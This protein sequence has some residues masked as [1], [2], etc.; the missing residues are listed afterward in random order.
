MY[1]QL[2]SIL[3]VLAG[4]GYAPQVKIDQTGIAFN[5]RQVK[6]VHVDHGILE[7]KPE[8]AAELILD[9]VEKALIGEDDE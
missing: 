4:K 9:E 2:C 7:Q 6:K 1:E 5:F 8:D 3:D